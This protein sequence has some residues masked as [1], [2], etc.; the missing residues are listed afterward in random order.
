[1][2]MLRFAQHDRRFFHTFLRRGLHAVARSAGSPL[3][4][5]YP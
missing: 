2:Q 4:L 1:M 5:E 3:R